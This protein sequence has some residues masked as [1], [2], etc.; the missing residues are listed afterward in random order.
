VEA[1]RVTACARAWRDRRFD[2]RGGKK[3][4]VQVDVLDG[5]VVTVSACEKV[6]SL[7]WARGMGVCASYG[8]VSDAFAVGQRV[9]GALRQLERGEGRMRSPARSGT[10]WSDA[11][12]RPR[13]CASL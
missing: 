5:R 10:P 6:D 1:R 2:E 8:A 4:T 12:A 11:G 9:E 7:K 3:K 13:A